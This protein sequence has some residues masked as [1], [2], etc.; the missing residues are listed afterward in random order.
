MKSS[1]Q[2]FFVAILPPAT[3]L[4]EII[5]FQ[6]EIAENYGSEGA[7]KSP[8]HLT[9]FPP[10]MILEDE[11][12]DVKKCLENIVVELSPFE[13]RLDNFGHFHGR[14]LFLN[15]VPS[16]QLSELQGR[17]NE[18][19]S[20]ILPKD[21]GKERVQRKDRTFRPHIT[22]ASKDLDP[23]AFSDAWTVFK[24]QKYIRTFDVAGVTLLT[25]TGKKWEI[26]ATFSLGTEVERHEICE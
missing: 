17:M 12:H 20:D 15:A 21:T 6:K 24:D 10:F 1:Q 2:L 11:V 8:P 7:M 18:A 23:Q 22:I 26:S 3:L 13:I 9:L 25:H 16:D 14:V 4:E 19:L 5:A